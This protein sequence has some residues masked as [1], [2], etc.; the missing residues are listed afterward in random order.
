M[1][2]VNKSQI[3]RLAALTLIFSY[4]ELLIPRLL[5]FFR[6]GLGNTALLMGLSAGLTFP[7]FMLLSLVKAVAANLMAG[8]SVIVREYGAGSAD[9]NTYKESVKN[10]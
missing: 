1:Q 7:A 3:A 6:L 8:T 4:T 10:N 2:S 5:P 9:Y